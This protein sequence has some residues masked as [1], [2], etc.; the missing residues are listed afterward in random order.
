MSKEKSPAFQF[1]PR[2]W[3]SDHNVS[4]L[5]YEQEGWYIHLI[6]H[7]WMEGH[8]P[9]DPAKALR[10][11]GIRER[12]IAGVE[13]CEIV[14]YFNKRHED[15]AELLATCFVP[16]A[17][18]KLNEAQLEY[19]VQPR[20]EKERHAQELRRQER[21]ESGKKGGKA[22]TITRLKNPSSAWKQLQAKSSSS[23]SSSS[24]SSKNNNT[25]GGGLCEL[26][27]CK[28][29]H[30]AQ[31]QGA[32]D[33]FWLHYPRHE[34]GRKEARKSWCKAWKAGLPPIAE[35]LTWIRIATTSEQWSEKSKIPH[36]TTW[37]NQKRWEGDPPPSRHNNTKSTKQPSFGEFKDEDDEL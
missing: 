19:L 8:I 24:A 31:C 30:I 34:P 9:A 25:C 17:Q 5:S 1:Y 15:M 16:E 20:I 2:D 32:F 3:L 21:S 14:A 23:S 4:S 22:S 13:E 10:L 27:P 11:L 33:Q 35:L 7:C 28:N 36:V 26:G 6:C 18:L 29:G 37:L 12:D